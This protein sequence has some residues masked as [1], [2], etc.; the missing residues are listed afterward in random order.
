MYAMF[1]KNRLP[2]HHSKTNNSWMS[3]K[4]SPRIYGFI[5]N[6]A[7]IF[8]V[9]PLDERRVYFIDWQGKVRVGK[10]QPRA[11][12]MEWFFLWG[13]QNETS[14]WSQWGTETQLH[15]WQERKEKWRRSLR[16]KRDQVWHSAC[17]L[18]DFPLGLDFLI[19]VQNISYIMKGR[20][21]TL[22]MMQGPWQM[23]LLVVS[24]NPEH[25]TLG[26][27]TTKRVQHA[28]GL[29]V[30]LPASVNL[31]KVTQRSV[32]TKLVISLVN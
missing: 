29:F 14:K 5:I 23:K 31:T 21:K 7:L 28:L 6:G 15:Y 16:D 13:N 22:L 12:K 30:L 8:P 17:H 18:A 1:T 3:V 11:F 4:K 25:L 9:G 26:S 24:K 20:A 10:R 19:P 27:C 32:H 2:L